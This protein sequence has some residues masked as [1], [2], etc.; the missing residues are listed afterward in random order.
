[1]LCSTGAYCPTLDSN[2]PHRLLICRLPFAVALSNIDSTVHYLPFHPGEGPHSLFLSLVK[3]ST[4][5][6]GYKP[7]NAGTTETELL[8]IPPSISTSSCSMALCNLGSTVLN[9]LIFLTTL[10]NFTYT[11]TTLEPL[12]LVGLYAASKIFVTPPEE[13]IFTKCQHRHLYQER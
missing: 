4:L 8:M 5:M 13:G 12:L 6:H 1:V 10:V 2:R 9:L 11:L 3:K 7:T